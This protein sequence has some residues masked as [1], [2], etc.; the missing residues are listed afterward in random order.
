M[1]IIENKATGQRFEIADGALYPKGAYREITLDKEV[2][3]EEPKVNPEPYIETPIEP[4]SQRPEEPKEEEK[5]AKKT[6]KRKSSKKS[7]AKKTT[8]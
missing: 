8:E 4:E 5:P 3:K 1:K 7:K 2:K 6:K